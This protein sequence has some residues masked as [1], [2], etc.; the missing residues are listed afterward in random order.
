MDESKQLESE[1]LESKQ[2]ESE[3]WE[4]TIDMKEIRDAKLPDKLIIMSN[5]DKFFHEAWTK[6]RNL[7][8][9]PHPFR[10]VLFGP[11][12]VGKSTVCL[13]ILLRADPPFEEVF[14]VHCDGDYT[15]EYDNIDCEFLDEIPAPSD[16]RGA[17]KTLVILEDLEFKQMPKDQKRN[18]DRLNG[19]VSTHK[20]ISTM[21]CA[22]DS[23]NV[24]PSVRRNCNFWVIWKSPDIDNM[25]AICR[26]TG[27]NKKQFMGIFDKLLP[28]FHDSLWVDMTPGTRAKLR[29]NGFQ[30]IRI[31]N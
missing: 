23:F 29:K 24:P 20:N 13:N 5:P 17:V 26:R 22:Q 10:M 25:S 9:I 2:L 31:K 3:G 12:N 16:F 4:T 11:P 6:K 15:K 7:V 30:K 18:L 1:Q 8:N 28:D 19:Y 27:L 14:L 21:L